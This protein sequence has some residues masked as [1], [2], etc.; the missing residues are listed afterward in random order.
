LN[1]QQLDEWGIA[2]EFALINKNLTYLGDDL[3]HYAEH[4]WETSDGYAEEEQDQDQDY[5]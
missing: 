4:Q 5:Y 3:F 2:S 1:R